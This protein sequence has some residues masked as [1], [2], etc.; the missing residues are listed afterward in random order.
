M[1]LP[2]LKIWP[3]L[4]TLHSV[5]NIQLH[6]R[7]ISSTIMPFAYNLTYNPHPLQDVP[8]LPLSTNIHRR[9]S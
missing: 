1:N 3:I 2:Y 7:I 5:N 9:F 6:F 8:Y 4:A